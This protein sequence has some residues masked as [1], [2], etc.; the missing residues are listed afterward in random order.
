MRLLWAYLWTSEI[1]TGFH[2][3]TTK[4]LCTNFLQITLSSLGSSEVC[5]WARNSNID[6]S[7]HCWKHP[8]LSVTWHTAPPRSRGGR[9]SAS[10]P[11]LCPWADPPLPLHS[12]NTRVD[13]SSWLL[14]TLH[15]HNS[16]PI[17]PEKK[18]SRNSCTN[19]LLCVM[20]VTQSYTLSCLYYA[21]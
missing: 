6:K 12:L 2:I 18:S 5:E 10:S 20:S 19:D 8:V 16:P 17:I 13:T 14:L 3:H 11:W 4:R 21:R 1:P 9:R 7:P 15:F